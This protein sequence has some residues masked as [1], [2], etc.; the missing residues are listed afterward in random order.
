MTWYRITSIAMSSGTGPY[1]IAIEL[2]NPSHHWSQV[3]AH[4][5]AAWMS[6]LQIEKSHGLNDLNLLDRGSWWCSHGHDF[7]VPQ[8]LVDQES[9]QPANWDTVHLNILLSGIHLNLISMNILNISP[10]L[11]FRV[12]LNHHF[13]CE[14]PLLIN[15][16]VIL[17]SRSLADLSDI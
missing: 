13:M 8:V 10:S 6:P 1:M 12:L 9:Q 5:L 14:L 3:S 4:R 11:G 7:L 15:L 2:W 17:S 16:H